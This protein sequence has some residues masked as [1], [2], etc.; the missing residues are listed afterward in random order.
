[1]STR[2]DSPPVR[3]AVV[4]AAGKMGA[5]LCA[6]A[7]SEPGFELIGALE[8]A[9]SALIGRA[10]APEGPRGRAPDVLDSSAFSGDFRADAV[11]DFSSDAGARGSMEAAGRAGAAL[12]VGTTALSAGTIDA[13]R[14]ESRRRAVLVS[15]NMSLGVALVAALARR[16]AATLTGY[17][18]SIVEAHHSAKR[19]APSGTAL[20]L[21]DAARQG[22]AALSDANIVSIRGG[23]VVGEHTVRFA[24]PG[25]YVEL[26]HR[27]TSRDV[28]VRGALR[29]AAWLR[30][31]TPGWY[32]M[33]DV[34]G[35]GAR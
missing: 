29:A 28:F 14:D 32:T 6:L 27:A 31:K 26:T 11:I 35:L 24:G 9:G 2:V 30:G 25:E 22:G 17:D 12:L 16:A 34:L 23:D 15:P 5:R 1:M 20:R 19:D 4:G 13:L 33:E 10:A 8:R 18:C 21:A 3:I 7:H